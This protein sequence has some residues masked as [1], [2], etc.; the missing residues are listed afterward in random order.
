MLGLEDEKKMN[1]DKYLYKDQTALLGNRLPP[2]HALAGTC[3]WYRLTAV[4]HPGPP[5]VS[6]FI[7]SACPSPPSVT[8]L[9]SRRYILQN[10]KKNRR[11]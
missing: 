9:V 5:P 1:M 6:R 2:V 3:R 7:A 11:I 8:R 4:A 10:L